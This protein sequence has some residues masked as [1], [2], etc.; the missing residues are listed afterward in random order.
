MFENLQK[1]IQFADNA[2][3]KR[4]NTAQKGTWIGPFACPQCGK[5]KLYICQEQLSFICFAD[6]SHIKGNKQNLLE[7]F[8]QIGI[9]SE[10]Q[11]HHY[12]NT[13]KH[14]ARKKSKSKIALDI[15]SKLT[16]YNAY[17]QFPY[18]EMTQLAIDYCQDKWVPQ[19]KWKDIIIGFDYDNNARMFI[20][21]YEKIDDTFHYRG[22]QA[23][24]IFHDCSPKIITPGVDKNEFLFEYWKIEGNT[25]VVFEST[26]DMPI[27]PNISTAALGTNLTFKHIDKLLKFENIVICFDGDAVDKA[28]TYCKIIYEKSSDH[29]SNNIWYL[30]IDKNCQ[31][32]HVKK[33]FSNQC[34]SNVYEVKKQVQQVIPLEYINKKAGGEYDY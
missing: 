4:K 28:R 27:V 20:P 26:F 6:G 22:F 16:L 12:I 14:G 34:L 2:T 24:R 19:E 17:K 25:I 3:N 10:Q 31:I 1:A 13:Y 21:L 5:E 32:D 7:L 18:L 11:I 30:N 29:N 23:R 9:T 15:N 8:L 33:D